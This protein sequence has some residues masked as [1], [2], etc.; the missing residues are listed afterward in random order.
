[1][2]LVRFDDGFSREV[3]VYADFSEDKKLLDAAEK[4]GIPVTELKYE[5][6][7]CTGKVTIP[8]KG[9]YFLFAKG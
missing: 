5:K 1:M 7:V 9:C 6:G 3:S 2:C 8:A 4:K